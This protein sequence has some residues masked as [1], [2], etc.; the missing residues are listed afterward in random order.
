MR[1][2]ERPARFAPVCVQYIHPRRSAGRI[3]PRHHQLVAAAD[4]RT[5]I[6]QRQQPSLSLSLLLA[7]E[8]NKRSAAVASS[9]SWSS[10]AQPPP[11]VTPE[12][13]PSPYRAIRS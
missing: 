6:Q 2:C 8:M 9:G 7:V 11:A 1:A 13:F 5:G 3:R 10:D 12:M 4:G